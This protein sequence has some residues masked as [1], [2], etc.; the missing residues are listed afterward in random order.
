MPCHWNLL[1]GKGGWRL[2]RLR[3]GIVA[4]AGI[5]IGVGSLPMDIGAA[6]AASVASEGGKVDAT[7]PMSFAIPPQSLA[8]ALEA[9]SEATG[10]QVL[11]DSRL[12]LGRDCAGAKGSMTPEAALRAL[13]GRTDLVI[14]YTS[15]N[16][17]VLLSA[18]AQG[19]AGAA[20]LPAD[21]HV[22]SL[23]TLHVGDAAE[24][25]D[26]ADYRFYAGVV[27]ADIQSA[28][29]RDEDA[30]SGSYDIGLRLWVGPSGTVLRS[31]IF[32]SSGDAERDAKVTRAVRNMTIS[33]PPPASMPQPVSVVIV[34]HA[35]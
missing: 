28:L 19:A 24:A 7:G 3:W 34:A 8:T 23:D 16:D 5:L 31:Q 13:L 4:F 22:L 14:R 29:H 9:Y 10:I 11:Y 15:S 1:D 27:Q 20:P 25:G 18:V 35:L 21:D 33:K 6:F 2:L 26:Q 12:A 30:R 17:V 32:R